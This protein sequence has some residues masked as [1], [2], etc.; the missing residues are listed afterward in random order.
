MVRRYN[1]ILLND[2]NFYVY[3]V[4]FFNEANEANE[5]NEVDTV[6]VRKGST[7]THLINNFSNRKIDSFYSYH[8]LL[9]MIEYDINFKL[10]AE[11]EGN[12][13]KSKINKLLPEY[14][15]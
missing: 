8:S 12:M 7:L 11:F 3:Q 14:M 13:T 9:N 5:D 2:N 4:H 6:Y 10:L 1:Y 15:I